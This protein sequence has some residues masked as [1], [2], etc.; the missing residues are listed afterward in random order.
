MVLDMDYTEYETMPLEQLAAIRE[1]ALDRVNTVTE[2]MKIRAK[3]E[4]VD[5]V[6]VKTIA[7]KAYVSRQT[8]YTWLAE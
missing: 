3:A 6:P 4:H 2:A 5:G 8:V 7:R 1:H